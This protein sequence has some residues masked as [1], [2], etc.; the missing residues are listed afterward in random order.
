MEHITPPNPRARYV[1]IDEPL[2][3]EGYVDELVQNMGQEGLRLFQV[4]P[5]RRG[6]DTVG[7]W[8]FF[9]EV[10][11]PVAQAPAPHRGM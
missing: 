4:V 5:M 1:H 10:A 3:V 7:F 9:S 11:V 2:A 8:L 6:G